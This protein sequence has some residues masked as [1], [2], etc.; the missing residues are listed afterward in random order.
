MKIQTAI[1]IAKDCGLETAGEAIFNI[2]LHA[3]N[4]FSYPDIQKEIE[5]SCRVSMA[6]LMASYMGMDKI[7]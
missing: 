4:L 2:K 3:V 6:S 1:E 5:E 7:P